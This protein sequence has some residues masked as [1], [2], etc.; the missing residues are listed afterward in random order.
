[1][2]RRS[3]R[4]DKSEPTRQTE[5]MTATLASPVEATRARV[6]LSRP[7]MDRLMKRYLPKGA[8]AEAMSQFLTRVV[9]EH[10][11]YRTRTLSRITEMAER[12]GGYLTTSDVSE[13]TGMGEFQVANLRRRDKL[14][15]TFAPGERYPRYMLADVVEFVDLKPTY[16]QHHN[17]LSWDFLRHFENRFPPPENAAP[18]GYDRPD[19]AEGVPNVDR[20]GV[21]QPIASAL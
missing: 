21:L 6:G 7:Q 1:M 15:A 16:R 18:D 10:D 5:I 8:S 12:N 13:A 17:P 19:T 4:F 9:R 11:R 2:Y 20:S 3:F 14:K